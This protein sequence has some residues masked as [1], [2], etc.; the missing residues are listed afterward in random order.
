MPGCLLTPLRSSWNCRLLEV[1][2][3]SRAPTAPGSVSGGL[4]DPVLCVSLIWGRNQL[5]VPTQL[6]GSLQVLQSEDAPLG[7]AAT[8][9]PE[10]P[11][12][13][14]ATVSTVPWGMAIFA[15]LM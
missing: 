7:A 3:R 5:R 4:G 12:Q 10:R 1:G 2:G 14:V 9:P 8:H 15:S 11:L 13:V 6:P